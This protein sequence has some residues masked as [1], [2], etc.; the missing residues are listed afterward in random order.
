MDYKFILI[1]STPRSASTTLQRILNTI[2]NSNING[3]NCGAIINILECYRNI[4]KTVEH[5]PKNKY[6]QVMSLVR[7]EKWNVKPCF[8]NI[9][10][11]ESVKKKIQDLIVNILS[12]NKNY[13]II[14]FKEIMWYENIELLNEF[15][16]LFP[17]TKIV[18]HIQEDIQSQANSTF[19][20]NES[21]YDYLKEYT[22]EIVEYVDKN[23]NCY[24]STREK[25]FDF[26]NIQNMCVYLEELI[27]EEDYL[28]IINSDPENKNK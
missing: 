19:F 26:K 13:K 20:N 15:L 7:L 22:E 28:K 16:E 24:L 9:F 10:D 1:V 14:G 21:K 17:N 3:E 27:S 8:Y 12:N 11:F 5:I 18:C 4:K 2:P 25:L 23:D 6:G